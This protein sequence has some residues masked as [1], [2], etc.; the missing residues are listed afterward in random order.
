MK[1]TPC[2]RQK[3]RDLFNQ[4][5]WPLWHTA[6]LSK[7]IIKDKHPSNNQA[8]EPF[9]TRSQAIDVEHIDGHCR[10]VVHLYKRTDGTIGA[11]GRPDPFSFFE[12]HGELFKLTRLQEDSA[13]IEEGSDGDGAG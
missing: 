1:E 9:C 4:H 3:L 6:Q 11:S 8:N 5:L 7:T 13:R 10:T 12:L 2:D